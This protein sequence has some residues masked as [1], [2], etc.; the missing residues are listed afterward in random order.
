MFIRHKNQLI[1]LSQTHDI[2]LSKS[3]SGGMIHFYFSEEEETAIKFDS[4]DLAETTF[5]QLVVKLEMS[6]AYRVLEL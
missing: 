2:R 3:G 5:E 1:N 6:V 4:M